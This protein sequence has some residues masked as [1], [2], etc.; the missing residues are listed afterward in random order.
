MRGK[1][2][3]ERQRE[4]LK[5]QEKKQYNKRIVKQKQLKRMINIMWYKDKNEMDYNCRS[6]S[7]SDKYR[8]SQQTDVS[9]YFAL[10]YIIS[11]HI[12]SYHLI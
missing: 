11:F 12:I 5:I 4:I 3:V 9:H 10:Y 2:R 6:Y 8:F 7:T 1:E